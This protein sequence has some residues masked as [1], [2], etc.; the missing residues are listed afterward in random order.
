MSPHRSGFDI[1][2]VAVGGGPGSRASTEARLP[3]HHEVR[4]NLVWT[5][6]PGDRGRH[7]GGRGCP[8]QEGPSWSTRTAR[9]AMNV[10]SLPKHGARRAR[11][12][13]PLAGLNLAARRRDSLSQGY[14]L[15]GFQADVE[16]RAF[17][18]IC[19][20]PPAIMLERLRPMCRR[21]VIGCAGQ[22]CVL[23][24]WIWHIEDLQYRA[25]RTI[26]P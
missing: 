1:H 20:R 13:T 23:G 3:A 14:G 19:S 25:L 12:G 10:A 21:G 9:E 8:W 22:L 11:S 24:L 2:E 6:R 4:W 26:A 15:R 7:D 5:L 16:T 18:E 17:S